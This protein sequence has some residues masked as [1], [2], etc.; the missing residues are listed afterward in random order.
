MKSTSHGTL[1]LAHQVGE[2]EHRALQ[3]ADQQQVAVRV[4][5]RDLG[6]ELA[7]AVLEVVGLDEDLADAGVAQHAPH[8]TRTRA[9]GAARRD[10]RW[11]RSA[12]CRRGR[13]RGARRRR[14]ARRPR[15]ARGPPP[16]DARSPGRARRPRR[17]RAL[18]ARAGRARA[19]AARA[20]R[21]RAGR[22]PRCSAVGTAASSTAASSRSSASVRSTLASAAGWIARSAGSSPARSRLRANA[23]EAFEASSRQGSPR[24]VAVGGGL[25]ARD[26][27]GAG[28]RAALARGH[29]EEGAAAGRRGEPVEHG[30]DL[31][32]RRVAGG[33]VAAAG[34]PRRGGV[35]RVARP[36]LQVAGALGPAR[37]LHVKRDAEPLAQ[38][39]A[40]RL[41]AG[42]LRAQPV[43][44]V[45]R[46]DVPRAG[47]PHRDVE[48]AD[49]VAPAGEQ[50]DARGG[51]GASRPPA[52]TRFEQVAHPSASAISG[53]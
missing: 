44:A 38:R 47:D 2:E 21:R 40:V 11:G 9:A 3:H 4:V 39:G 18:D 32:G 46:L 48:Q 28:G 22:R 36:R 14:R 33:D 49:R 52:R 12:A 43:V 30:L 10:P 26:A 15:G 7:H 17:R 51:P 1:D 23:G 13:P 34:E 50:H 37:A 42:R 16:C 25:L 29:A 19:A 24:A 20:P 8:P 53:R 35:A 41:V 45:Q 31:V 5:S 27:R 6:A